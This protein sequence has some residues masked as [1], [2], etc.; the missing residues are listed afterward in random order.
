[1]NMKMQQAIFPALLVFVM[2]TACDGVVSPTTEV[3]PTQTA[4][5]LP[6]PVPTRTLNL[7]AEPVPS[8][9]STP[10][11]SELALDPDDWKSWP[12]QPILTSQIAEI[13]ARGQELGNDP[14]AFSIFGDCQSKPEVFLGVYE[15]DPDVVAA[16]PAELQEAVANFTGSFNRESPTVKDAT[17][18]AGLLNPIWHEGKYTCTTDESPVECELRIHNPSF[19]FINTGTHWVTR[20]QEYLETIILQLLEAGVVPILATK[21]DDRYQGE[22][23]NAD[24]AIMAAKYGLPLWNFWAETLVLPEHGVYT[25]EGQGGLGDVY[26]TDQAILIYRLSA[27]QALDSVW[28]AATGR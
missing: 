6:S 14:H 25:K 18:V 1:M 11:P 20:N 28:R 17:T 8:P 7:P 4:T 5:L 13:Y 23:T 19:V 15:T 22:K 9:T 21:A 26:L 10:L 16:L 27:L 3:S 2:T 12:V 24:L